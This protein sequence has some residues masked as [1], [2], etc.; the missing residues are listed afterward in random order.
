[1]SSWVIRHS[2]IRVLEG[3]GVGWG[4][5]ECLTLEGCLSQC[6]GIKG[7]W[8]PSPTSASVGEPPH[9]PLPTFFGKPPPH[10]LPTCVGGG[11]RV[12]AEDGKGP[13]GERGQGLQ[14]KAHSSWRSDPGEGSSSQI[15]KDLSTLRSVE[16]IPKQ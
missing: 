6:C 16:F 3:V 11:G 5:A 14:L 2:V 8:Y 12:R 4:V 7:E 13:P 15:T 10:P 9:R 1:M